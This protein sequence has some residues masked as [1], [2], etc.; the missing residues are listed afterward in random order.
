MDSNILRA[1]LILV[2]AVSPSIVAAQERGADALRSSMARCAEIDD[3][4]ER[5]RCFDG[6]ASAVTAPADGSPA[7]RANPEEPPAEPEIPPVP[8]DVGE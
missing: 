4:A 7:P 8:E 1:I 6:I 3:D 5:I 2:L